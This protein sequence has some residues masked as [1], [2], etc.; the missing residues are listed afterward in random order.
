MKTIFKT[1]V[2]ALVAVPVFIFFI[3]WNAFENLN[4]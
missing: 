1:L 3:T 2:F 4:K